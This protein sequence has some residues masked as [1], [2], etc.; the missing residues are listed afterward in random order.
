MIWKSRFASK[1]SVGSDKSMM[2]L[3]RLDC[4]ADGDW[5]MFGTPY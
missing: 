4:C 5:P 1:L 3:L 2:I